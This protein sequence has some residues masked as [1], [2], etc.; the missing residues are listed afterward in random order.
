[1]PLN[2]QTGGAFMEGLAKGRQAQ[3]TVNTNQQN[4]DTQ[5]GYLTNAN[6]DQFL[7][8]IR[9]QMDQA[10]KILAT[11]ID[12]QKRQAIISAMD[13][14]GTQ[15]ASSPEA[16]Q[17]GLTGTI[18]Q[19]TKFAAQTPSAVD[20]AGIEGQA[21]GAKVQGMQGA[22]LSRPESLAG[23]GIN[24]NE[25]Q[26]RVGGGTGIGGG[27][28]TERMINDAAVL[29]DKKNSGQALSPSEQFKLDAMLGQTNKFTGKQQVTEGQY[30]AELTQKIPGLEQSAKVMK[31]SIDGLFNADGTDLSEGAKKNFGLVSY[32]PNV[33][34]GEAAGAEVKLKQLGGQI[35]LEAYKTLKGGGS[36]TEIEGQKAETALAR[37]NSAQS[38][39]DAKTALLE[40]KQ[41]IDDAVNNIKNAKSQLDKKYTYTGNPLQD[42]INAASKVD[43]ATGNQLPRTAEDKAG[44]DLSGY[45]EEQLQEML[46]NAQ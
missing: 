38:A 34:G 25:Y 42:S 8:T 35:F 24:I 17:F 9:D 32:L 19:M 15:A 22:G 13:M 31:Q 3:Q 2:I 29:L 41:A 43:A 36:I 18:T 45:T 5:S 7:K 12:P 20:V 11:T 23:A 44:G 6:K 37:L 4:A 16:Q 33:R 39:E 10:S 1:M 26:Q 46:K 27:T 40:L 21:L 30:S 28:G 14:L